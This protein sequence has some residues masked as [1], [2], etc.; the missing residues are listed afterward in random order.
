MLVDHPWPGIEVERSIIEAAG[1]ELIAGP[2]ET[3]TAAEVEALIALHDPVGIMTC[4][5]QISAQAIALPSILKVVTRMGV[6]LDNIAIDAATKRGAWV[7]NIPDYCTE[8]VSDHVIALLLNAWRGVGHFDRDV[9]TGHWR[10]ATASN[11]RLSQTTIGI[12]GHGRIGS[13]TA[14]KLARGFG[15]RVLVTSPSLLATGPPGRELEPHV[16]VAELATIQREA[17]A[18]TL[19]LPMRPQTVH[20]VNAAFLAACRRKPLLVNVSRGALVDNGALLQA[21]DRGL[22]SG[23]ALDV[24]EG[25][26]APPADLIARP[27]VTVTPHIAFASATSIAELCRRSADE[28]VRVLRGERPRHPCN[29][30]IP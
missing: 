5:A 9:K 4:W 23:A 21:L 13:A 14:R 29:Q 7:T 12:V 24:I 1:F 11:R 22:I 19:H 17:D 3:G 6:G 26:P 27:D 10:P 15:C 25:E 16:F 20:L 2:T 28:V 30:P 18:I 8:E